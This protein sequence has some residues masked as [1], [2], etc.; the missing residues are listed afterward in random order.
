[1]WSIVILI[2]VVAAFSVYFFVGAE[3]RN[4]IARLGVTGLAGDYVIQYTAGN[5]T[6]EYKIHGKVTSNP[7]GYYYFWFKPE[8]GGKKYIQLPIAHTTIEEM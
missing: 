4:K 2:V 1:M 8:Q 3:N 7:A 6:K 5:Y